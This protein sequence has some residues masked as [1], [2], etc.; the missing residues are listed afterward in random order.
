MTSRALPYDRPTV[1]G[2]P[3]LFAGARLG[4]SMHDEKTRV[5]RDIHD[6]HA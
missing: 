5:P 4:I 2:L 6:E 3:D 1:G